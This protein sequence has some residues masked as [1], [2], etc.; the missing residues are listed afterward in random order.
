MNKALGDLRQESQ[1][2]SSKAEEEAR[3]PS[4][5]VEARQISGESW[6]ITKIGIMLVQ[7]RKLNVS[8]DDFPIPLKYIDVQRQ[9]TL[10]DVL[11]EALSLFEP[12]IGVT[13]FALLNKK[14]AGRIYVGSRQTDEEIRHYKTRRYLTRRMV[15][16]V[17]KLS[18]TSHVA[19]EQRGI[20]SIPDGDPDHEEIMDNARRKLQIRRASAMPC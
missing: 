12:W 20:Y 4:P 8:K 15:K 19:G 10:I 11:H 5:D 6:K 2:T 13:R 9:K 18:A 7:E 14:S 1:S 17:E 3:D 16:H